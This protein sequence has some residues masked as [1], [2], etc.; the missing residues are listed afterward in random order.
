LERSGGGG[1]RNLQITGRFDCWVLI[2]TW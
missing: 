2:L 1:R